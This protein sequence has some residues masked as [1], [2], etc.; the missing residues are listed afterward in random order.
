MV[1]PPVPEAPSMSPPAIKSPLE[2][3]KN[4]F[5]KSMNQQPSVASPPAV[6]S[7]ET[8]K[9]Y[10]PFHA[11]QA[12][13]NNKTTLPEPQPAGRSR[14]KP[15]DD[16]DWSVV[17]SSDDEEDDDQP[18]G[19]GSA[20]HLASILFGTMAP[21]RPMSAMENTSKPNSPAP[22]SPP[23]P[24]PMP[25]TGAPPPPPMPS[26]GAPP[27]PPMPPAGGAPPPPPMPGS[28]SPPPPAMPAG[29]PA[30]GMPNRSGLLEQ[31]QMGKGLKKTQTK[32]R[33]QASTAGR[34][35]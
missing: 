17:E 25:S 13:D 15:S 31:I 8:K 22:G 7:P 16:D 29:P 9:D 4:P 19:G 24:P 3:S 12:S 18:P 2:E 34:I 28:F 33:S 6:A 1:I 21:P 30:G 20:K 14:A 11:M 10:N 32:D 27:P 5:W 23:P 26:G 35:L